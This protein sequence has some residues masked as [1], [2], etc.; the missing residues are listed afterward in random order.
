MSLMPR[1]GSSAGWRWDFEPEIYTPDTLFE[2]I[3]GEAEHYNDYDFVEM[4]TASH[5]RTDDELASLTIDIYDMGT[6]LNAFGI[7][8]SYC[9]P[10]LEF[11]SIGEEA[12]VSELNIRF[13]KGRFFV[14]LSAGSM[15]QVVKEA[16]RVQAVSLADRI[17]PVEEP[18]ELSFLPRSGRVPHTLQYLARGFMGQAAF[19]RALR[20]SYR[21]SSGKCS[22]FV[23]L[24]ES[25]EDAR[26]ALDEFR[27]S[28]IRQ[29][30]VTGG[31]GESGSAK[32]VAQT[33]YYGKITV[34]AH[35]RFVV[36]IVDYQEQAEADDL[37]ATITASLAA[38]GLAGL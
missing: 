12:I 34:Q 31:A 37:L 20:A 26:H 21:V 7:Y 27:E 10:E 33:Q 14:Q 5:A 24:K 17:R 22:A 9:R 13:Y 23:V 16:V 4:A 30:Q 11:A 19:E 8:S 38:S 18:A 28:L 32:L 25:D 29:G 3:N 2:Y 6:P 1:P 36:G 35:S 15:E